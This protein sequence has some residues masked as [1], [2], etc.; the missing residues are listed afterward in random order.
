MVASEATQHR[1]PLLP[2]LRHRRCLRRTYKLP[3]F[4]AVSS[5][6]DP[7]VMHQKIV[8]AELC[9]VNETGISALL[10]T[11]IRISTPNQV[12]NPNNGWSFSDEV[13]CWR[14]RRWKV[15]SALTM[16]K[17]GNRI[18]AVLSTRSYFFSHSP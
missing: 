11:V 14:R 2:P 9:S 4:P 17:I 3:G 1:C 16:T 6:L 7:R 10:L 5:D 8:Y 18:P 15:A 13:T 12:P